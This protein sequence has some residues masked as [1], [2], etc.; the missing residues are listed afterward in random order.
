M[1]VEYK[2]IIATVKRREAENLISTNAIAFKVVSDSF[3]EY[4]VDVRSMLLRSLR[5]GRGEPFCLPYERY[6]RNRVEVPFLNLNSYLDPGS[7]WT[8]E[9]PL[10]T[11]YLRAFPK[12]LI[13]R[14]LVISQASLFFFFSFNESIK[15]PLPTIVAF[16]TLWYFDNF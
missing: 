3:V 15:S 7:A 8:A 14:T 6:L 16:I 10:K 5:S 4:D 13:F 12:S 1:S 11:S 2:F 9:K